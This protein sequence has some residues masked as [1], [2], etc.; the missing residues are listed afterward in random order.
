M[1]PITPKVTTPA[2]LRVFMIFSC[3]DV[4]FGGRVV[5]PPAMASRRFEKVP[6]FQVKAKDETHT[7]GSAYGD[8][9]ETG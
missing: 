5:D 6:E 2:A 4:V 3:D 7:V 8:G 1:R 9:G